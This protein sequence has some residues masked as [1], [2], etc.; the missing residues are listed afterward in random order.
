L[1]WKDVV[2]GE[3]KFATKRNAKSGLD[4]VVPLSMKT[5][6]TNIYTSPD[7]RVVYPQEWVVFLDD[8][9]ILVKSPRAN[10]VF[11]AA[12]GTGFLS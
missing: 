7:T 5:S 4:S 3:K 12:P 8:L 10:Q 11:E 9:E 2:D 6:S 1:D